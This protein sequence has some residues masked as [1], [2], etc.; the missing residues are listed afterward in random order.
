VALFQVVWT[1][2]VIFVQKFEV[3]FQGPV[4]PEDKGAELV[5]FHSSV[6]AREVTAN[7]NARQTRRRMIASERFFI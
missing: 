6:A 3:V 2:A 4:P 5:G 7:P 1:E